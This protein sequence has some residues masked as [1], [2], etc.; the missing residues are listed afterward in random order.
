MDDF[1]REDEIIRQA[2]KIKSR[3]FNEAERKWK[4]TPDVE[5]KRPWPRCHNLTCNRT[6]VCQA[7]FGKKSC[8]GWEF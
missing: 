7:K 3:A 6:L 8:E 1:A 4:E 5:K 2:D